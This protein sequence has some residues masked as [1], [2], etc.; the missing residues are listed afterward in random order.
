M[1]FFSKLCQI[2]DLFMQAHVHNVDFLK[3]PKSFN[4]WLL[5]Y[6]FMNGLETS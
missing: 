2:Q 1:D 6:F 3:K 5:L 4:F